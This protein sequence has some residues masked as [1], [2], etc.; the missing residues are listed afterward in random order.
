MLDRVIY[1]PRLRRIARR[2]PYRARLG[3]DSHRRRHV[4]AG[5]C[6]TWIFN[7]YVL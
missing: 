2:Q 6:K 4:L 5:L 3:R 7:L 1:T